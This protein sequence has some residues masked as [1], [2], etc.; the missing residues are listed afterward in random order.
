MVYFPIELT[1]GIKMNKYPLWKYI[2]V[3]VVVILAF[4]YAL[5]NV[6]G[7]DPAVQIS[8]ASNQALSD[9]DLQKINA[10]L[11]STN[12]EPIAEQAEQKTLLI[13]FRN[14]DQQSKARELLQ[15]ALGKGYTVALNL[16]SATP[17]WLAAINAEPMKLGLDL[18][19]GIH[20]LLQVDVNSV[21]AH[22]QE[23]ELRN[24]GQALRDKE[25]R[26]AGLNR[27]PL[28]LIL[29]FR[30]ATTRDEANQLLSRQFSDFV[31]QSAIQGDQYVLTGQLAPAVLQQIRQN[32]I[33]Q[34]IMT[35]RRRVNELGVSEP[36]VQ[37]Q[38]LDRI[39]VDLPGI[40][41]A[42]RAQNIV[43]KTASLEFH[44]VDLAHD[45]ESAIN[46]VVPLGSELLYY[47]QNE[48]YLLNSDIVLKGSSITNASASIGQDGR[49][50][51]NIMLG[52]GG[53]SAFSRAT[54]ANVG[55]PMAT[56][57]IE[58]QS[59]INMVDGKPN[60]TYK[61]IREI[62]NVATI[63]QPLYDQ[64]EITGLSSMQEAN[65]L[66]LLLRA[67]SLPTT[68]TIIE[69]QNIGPSLG[70]A[71]IDKGVVSVIAGLVIIMIFTL[72]YYAGFG[73]IANIGL[74]VNLIFLVA[75]MSLLG[76]VLTLPGIAGMVLTVGMA[77]DANVLINERIREELRGGLGIA[78]SIHAGYERALATIIDSNVTTLIAAIVLL[79]IGSGPVKGFAV[80]L[81]IGILTSLFTAVMV[82][83]AIVNLIYGRR[84][85]SSISIGMNLKRITNLGRKHQA[86][87]D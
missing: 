84:K 81:T 62:I 21:I 86:K 28:G 44:M 17:K 26:Y 67:G 7:E 19:G 41:D 11:A 85:L 72:L 48:P 23:G 59:N 36:V 70:K 46:G 52:G 55:K 65:N 71:N 63:Q 42:A 27:T 87:N 76:A 61:K 83:R 32:T 25:I 29:S 39:S 14:E 54:A 50:Q 38:G 57:Y 82:T 40:Q 60:I 51:V 75:L 56:V 4:I 37:Q 66:A 15:T 45:V 47:H 1:A 24:I 80:T 34:A 68:V 53:E 18:R 22:R 79:S 20:F 3:I 43:G 64:F 35:L 16:A 2:L 31:W 6:Y 74:A 73:L 9:S 58:T 30:D 8:A 5:P 13:R 77:I 10:A 78:A 12:I 49:P 69:E 33:G